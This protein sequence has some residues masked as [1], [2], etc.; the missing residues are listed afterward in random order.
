MIL[1]E[2]E[3]RYNK[4]RYK[5]DQQ[6]G[7]PES[8]ILCTFDLS[9]KANIPKYPSQPFWVVTIGIGTVIVANLNLIHPQSWPDHLFRLAVNAG[10][11]C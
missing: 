5:L 3:G 4:T 9:S 7:I 11:E 2:Q 10:R 8:L 1:N 6:K